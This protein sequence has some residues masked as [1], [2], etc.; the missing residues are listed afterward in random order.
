MKRTDILFKSI[1][2]LYRESL[3]E[4]DNSYSKKIIK[5]ILDAMETDNKYQT[6]NSGDEV[7]G[8]LKKFT[9]DLVNSDDKPL[10]KDLIL[11]SVSLIVD[12]NSGLLDILAGTLTTSDDIEKNKKSIKVLRNYLIKYNN[13]HKISGLLGKASYDFRNNRSSIKSTKDFIYKLVGDLQ[14]FDLDKNS[15]DPAINNEVDI[16][17]DEELDIIMADIKEDEI[18]TTKLMTGWQALNKMTGGGFKRGEFVCLS[19]LQHQ[20]KSGA[21]ASLFA[22]IAMNNEPVNIDP[23]KKPLLL[24]LSLEDDLTILIDFLYRYLY[25]N[26]HNELPDFGKVSTK[27]A[28]IYIRDKLS[29]KG[30]NIK[31]LRIDPTNWSYRQTFDLVEKYE[32]EGYELHAVVDDYLSLTPTVGCDHTGP[33]GTEL[34]SLFRINRNY[35]GKKK[36]TFI[37][38]HQ[39]SVD[40]KQLIRNGEPDSTFVKAVINKGYYSGSRQLDQEIDLEIIIHKAKINNQTHLTFARGKHRGAKILDEDAMYFALP[41]PKKM[42]IKEDI[43]GK[44]SSFGGASSSDD[45]FDF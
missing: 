17:N 31:M 27:E 25:T 44:D 15:K 41:F 36:I 1:T 10:D 11:Q 35:F 45:G 42:P 30:Y 23:T 21:L 14:E 12:R 5:S 18:N 26:E 9:F 16:N 40:A 38:G 2:L 3:I 29:A 20:Y 32:S 22:Q 13:E 37:T 43:H 8:N 33:G 34:R 24:F 6:L 28:S 7:L 39:L 4:T 19:A